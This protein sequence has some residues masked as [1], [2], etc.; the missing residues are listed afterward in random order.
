[1]NED[2]GMNINK[3]A[4]SLGMP[5]VNLNIIMCLFVFAP[6]NQLVIGEF[7]LEAFIAWS[8]ECICIESDRVFLTKVVLR[9]HFKWFIAEKPG[10][11]FAVKGVEVRAS[12][13]VK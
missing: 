2:P 12:S 6:E 13:P 9:L 4:D 5:V 11:H 10:S 3:F 1:M 8:E 7:G